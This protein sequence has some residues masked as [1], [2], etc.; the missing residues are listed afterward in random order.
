MRCVTLDSNW[1]E[2]WYSSSADG[3]RCGDVPLWSSSV[4][5]VIRTAV[6]QQSVV[7]VVA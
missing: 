6:A 1:P 3:S 2:T 5:G 4:K 7:I